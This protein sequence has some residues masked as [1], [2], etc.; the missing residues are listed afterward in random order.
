MAS[1]PVLFEKRGGI[2]TVTLNRP[3]KLN[4]ITWRM[5]EDFL[6]AVADVEQL[7]ELGRAEGRPATP[8]QEHGEPRNE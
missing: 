7:L 5:M 6:D 8:A 1:S 3:D 2:A 4:A